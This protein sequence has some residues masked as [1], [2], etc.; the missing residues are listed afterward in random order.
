[1]I[2]YFFKLLT[3]FDAC[4]NC[5]LSSHQ[6]ICNVNSNVRV[7]FFY[8]ILLWMK[9]HADEFLPESHFVVAREFFK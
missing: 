5:N 9:S 6:F 2:L 1:M 4:A 3:Q 7:N 8:P